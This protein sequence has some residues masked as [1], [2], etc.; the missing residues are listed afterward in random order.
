MEPLIDNDKKEKNPFRLQKSKEP[1][2]KAFVDDRQWAHD[3]KH[4]VTSG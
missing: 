1:F 3:P 4:F 2:V